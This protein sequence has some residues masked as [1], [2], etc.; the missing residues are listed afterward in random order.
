MP[1]VL[2]PAQK[3]KFKPS[4]KCL[5][6]LETIAIKL[7]R[8]GSSVEQT[9][10]ESPENSYR[11]DSSYVSCDLSKSGAGSATLVYKNNW[12]FVNCFKSTQ[13]KFCIFI[14]L[15]LSFYYFIYHFLYCYWFFF[16]SVL[17]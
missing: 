14:L 9:L 3:S 17:S 2:P 12:D 6:Y 5:L 10:I 11:W 16:L 7:Y 8:K 1:V 4:D 15:H 13:D